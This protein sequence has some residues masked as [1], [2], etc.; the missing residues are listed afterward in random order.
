VHGLRTAHPR[1]GVEACQRATLRERL[2]VAYFFSRLVNLQRVVSFS[3]S[4][5][6]TV[7]LGIFGTGVG[8]GLIT[9][10]TGVHAS[11]IMWLSNLFGAEG[12][13]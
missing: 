11:I 7:K 13:A 3:S 1:R 10:V 2:R 4:K 5:S 12:G 6:V 9:G 8:V